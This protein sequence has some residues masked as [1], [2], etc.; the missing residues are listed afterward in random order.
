[1]PATLDK[2][3]QNIP[4]VKEEKEDNC[5]TSADGMYLLYP[6]LFGRQIALLLA[7]ATA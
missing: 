4:M 1:M 5:K 3:T 6:V 7:V 2:P